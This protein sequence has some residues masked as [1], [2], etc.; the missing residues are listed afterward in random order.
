V[1]SRLGHAE[2]S[3]RGSSER[4]FQP[5]ISSANFT[6]GKIFELERKNMVCKEKCKERQSNW[7]S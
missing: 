4:A 1:P 3:G 5:G 2:Y 6:L 7:Q